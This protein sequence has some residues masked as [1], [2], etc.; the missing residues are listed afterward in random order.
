MLS[1][2]SAYYNRKN[3][4]ITFYNTMKNTHSKT[5]LNTYAKD[6]YTLIISFNKKKVIENKWKTK[7]PR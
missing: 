3:E 5:I 1:P 7:K 6:K 4:Y 2:S